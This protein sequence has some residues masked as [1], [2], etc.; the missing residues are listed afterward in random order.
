M[1]I[2]I[3]N[4]T[5]IMIICLFFTSIFQGVEQNSYFSTKEQN[6]I[7]NFET[8][9]FDEA[10]ILALIGNGFGDSYFWIKNQLESW[11]CN[12]TTAGLSSPCSSCPNKPQRPV[13][14]DILIADVDEEILSQFDCIF[15]PSGAHHSLL[16]YSNLTLDVIST[17]YEKGLVIASICS[18]SVPIARA[19]GIVNGVKVAY[20]FLSTDHMQEAGAIELYGSSVVSDSRIITT[21]SGMPYGSQSPVYHVCVAMAKEILGY[22]ALIDATIKPQSGGIGTNYSLTVEVSDLTDI[23]YGNVS[24]AVYKVNFE[25]YN[26]N[27]LIAATFMT[28]ISDNIYAYNFTGLEVGSYQ[29]NVEVNSFGYGKEVIRNAASFVLTE[30]A[31]GFELF[32]LISSLSIIW[33]ILKVRRRK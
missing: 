26:G 21:S 31:P 32:I 23:F 4:F 30:K 16:A 20:F 28:E 6:N 17:A 3:G 18:G 11:G 24:T 14:P 15:I 1:G 22:S 13:T 12:F 5:K 27:E 8:K 29:I 7:T 25:L 19:H 10:K 2:I 33:Y 9:N